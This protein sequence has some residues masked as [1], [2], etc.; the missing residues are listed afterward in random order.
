MLRDI[1]ALVRDDL[2][3]VVLLQPG[4]LERVID[5]G[6]AGQT[7]FSSGRG[8]LHATWGISRDR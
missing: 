8:S 1:R 4:V 3:G 2:E 7:L 5:A 6:L